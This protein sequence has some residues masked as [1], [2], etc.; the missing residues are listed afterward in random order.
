MY[1]DESFVQKNPNSSL[2]SAKP[3][4]TLNRS[5]NIQPIR[6]LFNIWTSV[7][8]GNTGNK[9]EL[10]HKF[11]KIKALNFFELKKQRVNASSNDCMFK[12]IE[13]GSD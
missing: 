5:S 7:G 12:S 3:D 13:A 1:L 2:Q 9:N 6:Q 11:N 4:R 10:I 8:Y